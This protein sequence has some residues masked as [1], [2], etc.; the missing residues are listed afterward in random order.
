LSPAQLPKEISKE[1]LLSILAIQV[2]SYMRGRDRYDILR[3][4][5]GESN[6]K[7]IPVWSKFFLDATGNT[8]KVLSFMDKH[9]SLVDLKERMDL[10]LIAEDKMMKDIWCRVGII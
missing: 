1:D 6:R 5:E 10:V 8:K 7:F 4:Y 3:S 2:V 9:Y